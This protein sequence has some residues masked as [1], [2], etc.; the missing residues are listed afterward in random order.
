[1]TY[2]C[3]VTTL[4]SFYRGAECTATRE[5]PKC[6]LTVQSGGIDLQPRLPAR[7]DSR[8]LGISTVGG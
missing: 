2:F 5:I 4:T 1:V 6:L 3:P 8:G 7:F